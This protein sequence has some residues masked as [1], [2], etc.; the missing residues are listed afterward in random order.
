[1]ANYQQPDFRN[2]SPSTPPTVAPTPNADAIGTGT[3]RVN[4]IE[5]GISDKDD[6]ARTWRGPKK[7]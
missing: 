1:M 7:L 2:P 5:P 4:V 3:T 6:P